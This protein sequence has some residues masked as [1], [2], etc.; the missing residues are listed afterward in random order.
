M[1]ARVGERSRS[2]RVRVGVCFAAADVAGREVDI[3][4]D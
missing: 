3:F 1:E 4:V 2:G